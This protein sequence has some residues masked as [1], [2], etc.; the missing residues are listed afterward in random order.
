MYRAIMV[1]IEM[2]RE[3][4]KKGYTLL[5]M[6]EM[7]IGNTTTSAALTSVLLDLPVEVVTGKGAGLSK[8]GLER[9]K[10][11]YQKKKVFFNLKMKR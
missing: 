11:Q 9:K 1:G 4:K 10:H 3:C 2:A 7:G 6:G 8:D 5:G